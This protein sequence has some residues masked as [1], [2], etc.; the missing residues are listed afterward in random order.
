MVPC[1]YNLI[2]SAFCKYVLIKQFEQT[3]TTF[4]YYKTSLYLTRPMQSINDKLIQ[5]Q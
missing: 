1:N 3:D 2:S 4:V 5:L